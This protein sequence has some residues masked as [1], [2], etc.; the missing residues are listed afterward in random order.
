[1]NELKIFSD[2]LSSPMQLRAHLANCKTTTWTG[3]SRHYAI[4]WVR[5]TQMRSFYLSMGST[6]Y[7]NIFSF[8]STLVFSKQKRRRKRFKEAIE[9]EKQHVFIIFLTIK[10]KLKFEISH[11]KSISMNIINKKNHQVLVP[12]YLFLDAFRN[13]F[14]HHCNFS[15]LRSFIYYFFKNNLSSFIRNYL[16]NMILIL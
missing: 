5:I 8:T 4:G 12:N 15:T 13:I 10:W 14:G 9:A 11:R 6:S 1:M 16:I 3:P 7:A 2:F